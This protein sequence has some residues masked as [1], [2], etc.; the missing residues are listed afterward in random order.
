M[1]HF[2]GGIKGSRGKATRLGHAKTGLNAYVY[3][4]HSGIKV[5]AYVNER[6]E[7]CFDI[8]KNGGS[9]NNDPCA[10]IACIVAGKIQLPIALRLLK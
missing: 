8:Y 6:G 1:A 4:W 5:L 9:N 7:D 10:L 2:I 3:G